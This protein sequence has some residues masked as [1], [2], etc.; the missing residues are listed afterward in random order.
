MYLSEAIRIG[1]AMKPQ[2]FGVER[3]DR[4]TCALGAAYDGMGTINAGQEE[5]IA[6]DF[7]L[8]LIYDH[9]ELCPAC[10]LNLEYRE[11]KRKAGLICNMI[12]HL[13]D[14]HRW[15]REAIADYIEAMEVKYGIRPM[16]ASEPESC[17]VP[18]TKKDLAHVMV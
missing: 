7:N 16:V 3:D 14:Q 10:G 8:K 17:D 4:G 18:M 1:A 6:L 5:L 12:P 2:T 13:N 9:K 11:D 15:S